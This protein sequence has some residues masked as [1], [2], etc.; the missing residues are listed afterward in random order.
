MAATGFQRNTATHHE[1]T[2]FFIN[3]GKI[4]SRIEWFHDF[5]DVKWNILRLVSRQFT[6][7]F[8]L[9]LLREV[10]LVLLVVVVVLQLFLLKIELG[11]TRKGYL[12]T[13]QSRDC[14]SLPRRCHSQVYRRIVPFGLLWKEEKVVR[15]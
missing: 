14:F 5:K 1:R 8:S 11:F 4:Y 10:V 9:F 2:N 6:R 12:E 15:L 13:D 7:M 3:N